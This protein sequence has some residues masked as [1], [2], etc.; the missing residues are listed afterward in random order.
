MRVPPFS[1]TI[2]FELY[3]RENEFYVQITYRKTVSEDALPLEI[4]N[5][6]TMCPLKKFYELY[7]HILPKESE[8]FTTLCKL[9]AKSY[10]PIILILFMNAIAIIVIVMIVLSIKRRNKVVPKKSRSENIRSHS[11][12]SHSLSA[13]PKHV[14]DTI[15]ENVMPK[16]VVLPSK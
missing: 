2:L 5:C 9:K 11:L 8:D 14:L 15:S 16:G 7:D 4:P 6:G 3:E 1:S 13:I 10:H 12:R